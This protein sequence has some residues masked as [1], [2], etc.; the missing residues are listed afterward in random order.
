MRRS[1]IV[2]IVCLSVLA[3]GTAYAQSPGGSKAFGKALCEWMLLDNAWRL[4][5]DQDNPEGKM[6]FLPDINSPEAGD[7]EWTYDED[8]NQWSYAAEIDICLE[9]GQKFS[10]PLIF[11]YGE[12]YDDGTEDDPDDFDL[13]ALLAPFEIQVYLDGELILDTLDE[14]IADYFYGPEYFD[15][16]I[17]DDSA[18]SSPATTAIIW[19]SGYGFVHPPLS[20]GEHT[21]VWKLFAADEDTGYG[22]E[23]YN[24]LTQNITVGKHK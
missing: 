8:L 23:L 11:F 12:A 17:T 1:A 14:D 2:W 20:R 22:Y 15:E 10:M 4:G 16:E 9:P 5:G 18:F 3:L 13:V 21:L 7:G 19:T 6:V 24:E